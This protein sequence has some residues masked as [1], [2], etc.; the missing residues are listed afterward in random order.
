MPRLSMATHWLMFTKYGAINVEGGGVGVASFPAFTHVRID[1]VGVPPSRRLTVHFLVLLFSYDPSTTFQWKMAN[2]GVDRLVPR[3]YDLVCT[4]TL[5]TER[6]S[7]EIC[8]ENAASG[9]E[10]Y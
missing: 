7:R 10:Y 5:E 6:T 2:A 8:S 3:K 9:S 1:F 4:V